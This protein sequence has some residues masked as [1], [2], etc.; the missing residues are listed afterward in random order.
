[1]SDTS[2]RRLTDVT[3][4]LLETMLHVGYNKRNLV[5]FLSSLREES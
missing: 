4:D 5:S 2:I 3:C 1:M